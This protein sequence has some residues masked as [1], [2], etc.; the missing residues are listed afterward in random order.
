MYVAD[1]SGNPT[2]HPFLITMTTNHSRIPFKRTGELEDRYRAIREALQHTSPDDIDH[3]LPN[4][5]DAIR[6]GSTDEATVRFRVGVSFT[7][8]LDPLDYELTRLVD[9]ERGWTGEE[10]KERA[11]DR[12]FYLEFRYPPDPHF[13]ARALRGAMLAAVDRNLQTVQERREVETTEVSGLWKQLS[14]FL[15]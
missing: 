7:E 15:D 4:L 14:G 13:D 8:G 5:A 12:H 10:I 6:D 3:R 9:S 1:L 11:S 2:V